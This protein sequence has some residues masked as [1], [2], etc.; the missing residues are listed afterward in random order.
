MFNRHVHPLAD[1]WYLM[2]ID[3]FTSCWDVQT[4]DREISGSIMLCSLPRRGDD[5]L[6]L[7]CLSSIVPVHLTCCVSLACIWWF[8]STLRCCVRVSKD[9]DLGN[10]IAVQ[11]RT[12]TATG[13]ITECYHEVGTRNSSPIAPLPHL[14]PPPPFPRRPRSM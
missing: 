3:V 4:R 14:S 5:T 2:H 10:F 13:N 9:W 1:S 12:E 6:L 8:S 11:W 7:F